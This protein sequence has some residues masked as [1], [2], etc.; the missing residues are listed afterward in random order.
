MLRIG[1]SGSYGGA[2]LG[3]EAILAGILGQLRNSMDAKVT[4]FSPNA[5]DTRMRHRV[6]RVVPVR[7]LAR[8][9]V[10]PEIE[11]LDLLI[12]GG[13]G[14][15]YDAKALTYLREVTMAHELGV[16]V[17]VYAVSVGPLTNFE[18]RKA[19]KEALDRVATVTVRDRVSQRLLE[20][21]GVTA[22]IHVTADPALLLQADPAADDALAAEGLP[23]KER[24]IG[25]SVR[26]PGEAAP[27]LSVAHYHQL[28]AN[29][30]DFMV[31]RYGATLVFVPMEPK[32]LDQQ[33]S[34]AVIAGMANAPHALVLKR[35]YSVAQVLSM[36]GHF[37]FALGMRLHFLIFAALHR[38]PFL[39]L[40]YSDKVSGFIQEFE[41]AT[42]PMEGMNAGQLISYVDRAWDLRTQL[43]TR[44]ED[45][46]PGL[47]ARAR[48]TNRLLM[49][50]IGRIDHGGATGS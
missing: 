20:E 34:H 44:I 43:R 42:P 37:Q 5:E 36:M 26:E 4:V 28:L 9:E 7:E 8:E 32:V 22:P 10:R 48:E 15:L 27:N 50:L 1:I 46:L 40:P 6:D 17:F 35:D 21:I 14:I 16:P 19:V 24:L 49:E 3:D 30:A 2:N 33:H 31:D 47:Q 23:P 25:I 13:G 38:V 45:R 29:A 18:T 41:M 39:A 12:L 11:A